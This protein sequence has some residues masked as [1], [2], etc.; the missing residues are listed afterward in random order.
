[1][2]QSRLSD[3]SLLAVHVK[4]EEIAELLERLAAEDAT[5]QK[6]ITT[7]RDIAELTEVSPQVITRILV[8]MRGPRDD[9][10]TALLLANHE[11]RIQSL[12]RGKPHQTYWS[13]PTPA[14]FE[15][16]DY[17]ARSYDQFLRDNWIGR[18]D[19]EDYHGVGRQ[20]L[21]VIIVVLGLALILALL[22]ALPR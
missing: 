4:D 14:T 9:E 15:E 5:F 13:N 2:N 3:E 10:Q 1:M 11:H 18:I 17:Y 8:N 19:E 20:A 16:D 12:E 6:P 7:V 21:T 22:L